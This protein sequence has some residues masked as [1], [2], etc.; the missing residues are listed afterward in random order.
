MHYEWVHL[1]ANYNGDTGTNIPVTMEKLDHLVAS[2]GLKPDILK[3]DV[4]GYEGPVIEG[5]LKVLRNHNPIIFLE[6]HGHW[7]NRYGYSPQSVME[8]FESCGYLFFDLDLHPIRK[9]EKAFSVFAN[10][11]ICTK[12]PDSILS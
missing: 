11:I 3:I 6:L 4:D 9:A 10:R 7:I 8:M 12:N 1:I 2:R 5:G